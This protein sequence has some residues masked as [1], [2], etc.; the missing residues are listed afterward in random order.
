MLLLCELLL[1]RHVGDDRHTQCPQS[2][3]RC[4]PE[5]HGVSRDEKTV[6]RIQRLLQWS[7]RHAKPARDQ[8]AD[9]RRA[10]WRLIPHQAVGKTKVSHLRTRHT[11]STAYHECVAYR[12]LN[13][14][15][16]HGHETSCMAQMSG[17]VVLAGAARLRASPTLQW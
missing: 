8:R 11:G 15:A 9:Q 6:K 3:K 7:Q 13:E 5:V 12:R 4:V 1:A 16:L 10:V 14:Q 17:G 2:R